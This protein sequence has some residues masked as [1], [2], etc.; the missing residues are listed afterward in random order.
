MRDKGWFGA[1]RDDWREIWDLPDDDLHFFK[2][3]TEADV[4]HSELGWRNVAEY[5]AELNLEDEVIDALRRNL[6]VWER[7]FNGIAEYGDSME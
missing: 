5:A 7:Y 6:V 4:E 1:V 2:L 3:H